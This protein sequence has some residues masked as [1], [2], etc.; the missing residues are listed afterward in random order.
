MKKVT[1]KKTFTAALLITAL[2][3]AGIASAHDEGGT[4]AGG[5]APGYWGGQTDVWEVT[6]PAGEG[7]HHLGVSIANLAPAKAPVVSFAAYKLG[8]PYVVKGETDP[9]DNDGVFSKES[10]INGGSGSYIIMVKKTAGK[11]LA[12]DTSTQKLGKVAAQNYSLSI[13]CKTST[14]QHTNLDTQE[15]VLKQ[16]Q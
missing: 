13:H 11:I 7:A 9:K 16:N 2:G 15:A 1:I 12:T 8:L 4:L 3:Q 5:I 14:N 6:C 10:N